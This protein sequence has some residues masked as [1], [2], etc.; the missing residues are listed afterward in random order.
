MRNYLNARLGEHSTT[1]G[2]TL[3]ASA[4]SNYAQG[5][6]WKSTIIQS[7]VGLIVSLIPTRK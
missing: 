5:M 7:A 1:F 6:D 2:L 4:A 3:I